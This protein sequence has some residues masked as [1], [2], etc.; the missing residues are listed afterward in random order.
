MHNCVYNFR[1]Q[2]RLGFSVDV[3]ASALARI[4]ESSEATTW[5]DEAWRKFLFCGQKWT[6]YDLESAFEMLQTYSAIP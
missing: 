6:T 2:G 3:L 1:R 5:S 4:T